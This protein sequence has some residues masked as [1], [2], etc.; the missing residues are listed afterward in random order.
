MKKCITKKVLA[1]ILATLLTVSVFATCLVFAASAADPGP[2]EIDFIGYKHDKFN[3]LVAGD[4]MTVSE[5]T[6]KGNGGK[7]KDMNYAAIAV[8]NKQNVVT[9]VNVALGV[10]KATVVCPEGGYIISLNGNKAGY[11]RLKEVKV[12]DV[13]V[14][15]C[16]NL[17]EARAITGNKAISGASFTWYTPVAPKISA[18]ATNGKVA[19]PDDLSKLIDGNLAA[20]A[21][22]FNDAGLLAFE[23]KGFVHTQGSSAAVEA[24]VEFIF[25]LGTHKNLT[26]VGMGFFKDRTSMVDLPTS[27]LFEVS[28]DGINYF[29][30]NAAKQP[31]GKTAIAGLIE[32]TKEDPTA[33]KG[34]VQYSADFS[35][36]TAVTA[37][38]IKATITYKN[39]F[40]FASE[41]AFET[42]AT[43]GVFD[44]NTPTDVTSINAVPGAEAIAIYKPGAT[45]DYSDHTLAMCQFTRVKWDSLKKVFVNLENIVNPYP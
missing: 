20:G 31:A 14:L 5:L 33:L 24:T 13:I 21:T 12:G 39:G 18:T 3:S 23:N 44:L 32:D 37:R 15:S 22:A 2:I 26:A 11:D 17:P 38:Y 19:I 7:A 36:R 29:D 9:E 43:K 28:A 40:F 42:K 16:I 41:L 45:V 35:T 8:V 10:S 34:M 1:I 6:A 4:N 25:D 27:V 30:V